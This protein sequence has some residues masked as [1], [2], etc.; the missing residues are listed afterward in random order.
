MNGD[1]VYVSVVGTI[2]ET[3]LSMMKQRCVGW[4]CAYSTRLPWLHFPA[5]GSGLCV[6][7]AVTTISYHVL[8][9]SLG[10]VSG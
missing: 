4:G 6:D 10:M 3:I 9:T 7:L 8:V 1:A 2:D 5:V